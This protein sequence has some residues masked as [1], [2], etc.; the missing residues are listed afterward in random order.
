MVGICFKKTGDNIDG[1]SYPY[2][3]RFSKVNFDDHDLQEFK[4]CLN[5]TKEHIPNNAHNLDYD[6]LSRQPISIQCHAE[7]QYWWHN[8]H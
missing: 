8:I 2:Y 1:M 6:R 5:F 7:H 3:V 4:G